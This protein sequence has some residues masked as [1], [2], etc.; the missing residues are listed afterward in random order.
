MRSYVREVSAITED[1]DGIAEAQQSGGAGDLSLDG[2]GV[3]GGSAT[4]SP[5]RR[6][7]ITSDGDDSGTVF[8]VYGTDR[9]DRPLAEAINGPNTDVVLTLN[10][11]KTVTRIAIDGAAAGNIEVGWGEESVSSWVFL[12]HL[13]E[14][15]AYAVEVSGTVNY[16][17]EKTYRNLIRE[18]VSGDYDSS[19][20]DLE[21]NKTAALSG[22]IEAGVGAVRL[23][24][25]SGSGSCVLRV[26]PSR[27]R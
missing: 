22:V 18:G 6:I 17:I 2:V 10:V 12:G 26:I 21:T 5:P 9:K 11:F 19:A 20:V 3:S 8:T 27:G 7:Q 16:D 4:L 23:V 25:N 24:K 14:L 1:A 15:A 13:D